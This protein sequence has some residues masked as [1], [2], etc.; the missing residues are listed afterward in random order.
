M[1]FHP[2]NYKV[3]LHESDVPFY[4]KRFLQHELKKI[5]LSFVFSL[6]ILHSF[7]SYLGQCVPGEKFPKALVHLQLHIIVSQIKTKS[8]GQRTFFFFDSPGNEQTYDQDQSQCKD[9]SSCREKLIIKIISSGIGLM[10]KPGVYSWQEAQA[11][12]KVLSA[13]SEAGSTKML[14]KQF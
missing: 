6:F 8:S 9:P 11:P 2:Y 3:C 4:D 14:L 7:H 10:Q 12:N 5:N 13:F 1:S